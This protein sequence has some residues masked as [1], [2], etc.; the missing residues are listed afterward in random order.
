MD[1]IF[2]SIEKIIFHN[3]ETGYTIAQ[4]KEAKKKD[5]TCIV[6]VVPGLQ[7]GVT[8]RCK[9]EWKNHLVHGNQFEVKESIQH[10][11]S[12]LIGIEKYLGSGL[13]HGI[14]PVYAKKIVSKFGMGTLDVLEKEPGRLKEIKG[15]GKVKIS[16]IAN[17]WQEQKKIKDVMIFLQGHGISPAF[18]QK[19]FKRFGNSSITAIKENPYRLSSEINGIGFVG[20][21]KIAK[22][23]GIS[24]NSPDRIAAGIDYVLGQ[25]TGNGHVCYPLPLFLHEAST[26]LEVSLPE[27]EKEIETLKLAHKIKVEDIGVH[28]LIWQSNLFFAEIGIAKCLKALLKEPSPL[29]SIDPDKAIPWAEKELKMELA[30]AQREAVRLTIQEKVSIIT[31]GPGTGKS[32]ITKAILAI[33]DKLTSKILL[34][35]PTGRAAKR[36]TEITG[37]PA[38]TIHAKLE[39]DFATYRFKRNEENPLDCDLIVIDESSMIDTQLMNQLLKAIPLHAKVLLVGDVNQLPSVGPGTVLKDIIASTR[40]PT[41]IL[42]EI[43]RQAKGSRIIT[44]SHL[45]NQGLMP[46]LSVSSQ[47]DFFFIQKEDPEEVLKTILDLVAYRLPQKYRFN[48]IEDIQ[49]LAPM[50]KGVIGIHNLN[51]QLQKKLNKN[52]QNPLQRY[53]ETYLEGDKVM[54]IRNN[55]QKEVFNGDIGK[56]VAIDFEEQMM[57]IEFDGKTV[58]Y[59]FRELDEVQLAYAVSIHKYQGSECPCVVIPVHTAHFKMLHRN[60][61][62]TGVTRGKKLV[63][64]VGSKKALFIAVNNNDVLQRYTGLEKA[65]A[66]TFTPIPDWVKVGFD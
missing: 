9:G 60:L 33:F 19:I 24:H 17:C 49:V 41:A 66:T 62:Y 8:L 50:K 16:K 4:L 15:I 22:T 39:M 11:P 21:D 64:L 7:P 1:E 2:G 10:E 54:Q 37:K 26:I 59:L 14:G 63:I 27:V 52:N 55:Y 3:E 46:D 6:G 40:I 38:F 44:N 13:I 45:I 35:A 20:A 12:D 65:I 61:L 28:T 42:T 30:D 48:P 53:G 58:E 47:S 57:Q 56:I 43:F 23:L 32:T 5:L 18:A 51:L 29:R 34:V 25:L 36:M 31:G